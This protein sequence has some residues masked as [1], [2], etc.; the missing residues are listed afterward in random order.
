MVQLVSDAVSMIRTLFVN[1]ING[2]FFFYSFSRF[3][4]ERLRRT[5]GFLVSSV[6]PYKVARHAAAAR[7]PRRVRE[8]VEEGFVQF[9]NYISVHC[10]VCY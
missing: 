7:G 5:T 10:C 8:V 9:V 2:G 1:F 4:N 3:V 6:A